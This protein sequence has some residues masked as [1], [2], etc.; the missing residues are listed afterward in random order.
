LGA[1]IG[2]E[3]F[4]QCIYSELH[5]DRCFGLIAFAKVLSV[6]LLQSYSEQA[7]E[8]TIALLLGFHVLWSS[9]WLI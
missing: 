3:D 7:E 8:V 9:K 2:E 1:K 6:Y 4:Q 5:A